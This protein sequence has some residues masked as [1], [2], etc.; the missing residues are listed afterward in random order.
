[1]ARRILSHGTTYY[2]AKGIKIPPYQVPTG[3][4]DQPVHSIE[5][6]LAALERGARAASKKW[7]RN[8]KR[9]GKE[10]QQ[11]KRTRKR[12]KVKA[13]VVGEEKG[14]SAKIVIERC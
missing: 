12:R 2:F 13:N 1:M 4:S 5:T 14:E 11:P 8:C 3:L 7:Y 10:C 6:V 9:G